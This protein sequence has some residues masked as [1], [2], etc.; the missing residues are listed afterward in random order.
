[1]RLLQGNNDEGNLNDTRSV[2]S[3]VEERPEGSTMARTAADYKHIDGLRG[4]GALCVYNCH[5]VEL[6]VEESPTNKSQEHWFFVMI[7][8]TPLRIF[9]QGPFWVLVFF[10]I[11]GFVLPMR[12]F[13]GATGPNLLLKMIK[14]YFR[15]MIP[16][17]ASISIYY[18]CV[19]HKLVYW[20]WFS[21]IQ[22][23]D[24]PQKSFGNL[25]M[26]GLFYTWVGHTD[27]N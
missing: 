21:A 25:W 11:S 26:D 22:F 20:D 2:D 17:F 23:S 19:K 6:L 9:V 10:I 14:R 5:F 24:V 15:L 13:G 16:L 12:S 18:V 3:V 4:I 7:L 8:R 1:V 27:Y